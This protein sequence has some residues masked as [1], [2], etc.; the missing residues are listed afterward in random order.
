MP[1]TMQRGHKQH[2]ILAIIFCSR[3]TLW[4]VASSWCKVPVWAH[5]KLSQSSTSTATMQVQV[6]LCTYKSGSA[7]A[8][9]ASSLATRAAAA[10]PLLWGPWQ[11]VLADPLLLGPGLVSST[12]CCCSRH[13]LV[14]SWLVTAPRLCL[15][16]MM[17]QTQFVVSKQI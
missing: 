1:T 3:A 7:P 11:V 6:V 14:W 9:L 16:S 12:G 17:R 15:R 4:P 13:P 8:S 10:L 2:R 5:S